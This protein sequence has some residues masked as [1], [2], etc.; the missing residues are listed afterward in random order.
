M[1]KQEQKHIRMDLQLFADGDN[2]QGNP[3]PQPSG[4]PNLSAQALAML[5]A[6]NANA[7]NSP[8]GAAPIQL[9]GQPQPTGD[10]NPQNSPQNSENSGQVAGQQPNQSQ[11][12]EGQPGQQAPNNA[13]ALTLGKFK[14]P[15]ELANGYVNVER[16]YTQTRQ[17]LAAKNQQID[18]M[19]QAI[20]Q[21]QQQ[22]NGN[23]NPQMQQ[24]QQMEQ[25][26]QYEDAESFMNKFYEN[27]DALMQDKINNAIQNAIQQVI[28][29]QIQPIQQQYQ[30]QQQQAAFNQAMDQFK[31]QVPDAAQLEPAIQQVLN[32]NPELNGHPKGPMAAINIAYNMAKGQMYQPPTALVQD[33]NFIE[34]YIMNNP[35]IKNRLLQGYMQEL[36]KNQQAP[37]VISGQAGGQTPAMP[38][39][40]PQTIKDARPL[41]EQY[42]RR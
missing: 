14:S 13:D 28:L 6:A 29:P 15:E 37:T 19:Q 22:L 25:Q 3:S 42:L 1:A 16:A 41:A 11:P 9:Q 34:N 30:Q 38:P 12:T 8:E 39:S 4:E 35:E 23:V 10:N 21:M 33:K 7:N 2:T 36:Q 20:Q 24:M 31:S 32:Q 17:E 18:A 40:Q 27:P 26:P 5:Q